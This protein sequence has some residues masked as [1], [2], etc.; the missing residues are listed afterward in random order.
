VER[1]R[2][3]LGQPSRLAQQLGSDGDSIAR[4]R[5]RG[6]FPDNR[7]HVVLTLPQLLEEIENTKLG[8]DT[9]ANDGG[10]QS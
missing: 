2:G 6:A 3:W 5:H 1:A 8:G 4:G 10:G 7:K 9:T